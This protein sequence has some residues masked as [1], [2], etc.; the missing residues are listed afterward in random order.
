MI[1]KL[2]GRL[3]EKTYKVNRGVLPYLKYTLELLVRVNPKSFHKS[4]N[5]TSI[6]N[7][8]RPRSFHI[9]TNERAKQKRTSANMNE[10]KA[11]ERK[12]SKW[13]NERNKK[14]RP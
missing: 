1:P 13:Q 5:G 4:N 10:R 12:L 14:E 2:R 11:S 3:C 9:S 8:G 6:S 7:I